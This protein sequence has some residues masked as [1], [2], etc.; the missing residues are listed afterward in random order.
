M[1]SLCVSHSFYDLY[2]V[3]NDLNCILHLLFAHG[4][5]CRAVNNSDSV[6]HPQKHL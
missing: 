5:Q 2:T 4:G 1:F 6:E 3:E